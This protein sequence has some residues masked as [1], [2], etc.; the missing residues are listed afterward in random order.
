MNVYFDNLLWPFKHFWHL[1]QIVTIATL[2]PL[3]I[4]QPSNPQRI[5][6][7]NFEIYNWHS[8]NSFSATLTLTS[9]NNSYGYAK[10]FF[11]LLCVMFTKKIKFVINFYHICFHTDCLMFFI[12]FH[13]SLSKTMLRKK[14]FVHRD[15]ITEP[16]FEI[17]YVTYMAGLLVQK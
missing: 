5:I 14:W 16:N 10:L 17:I 1:L 12:G 4:S 11:F 7:L 13:K 8:Q 15:Y 2:I 6:S 9:F 3:S